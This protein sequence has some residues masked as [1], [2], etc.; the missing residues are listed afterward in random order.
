MKKIAYFF[1][2]LLI[3]GSAFGQT[4]TL[5]STSAA[6]TDN[7]LSVLS[8]PAWLGFRPHRGEFTLLFPYNDSTASQDFGMLVQL[9][10]LGFAGE[11]VNN[12]LYFYNRYT[13]GSGF[14]LGEG[15]YLG[16]S[17]D[18]Y[19]VVDWDGGWNIGMGYRPFSFLSAGAVIYDLNQPNRGGV[20]I[21][22]SY[23]FS[24]AFRPLGHKLTLSGDFLFTKP[25]G[26]SYGDSLDPVIRL[27]LMPLD[28]IKLTG[29]YRTDSK[30]FSLGLGLAIDN[31]AMGNF[32]N[33]D[34]DGK[35]L[36]SVTTVQ[37]SSDRQL[38]PFS[39][40]SHQIV[41]VTLD[42]KIGES[43]RMRIPFLSKH[44][45]KTLSELCEEIDHYAEDNKVDGLLIRFENPQLGFAQVQ[46]LRRALEK[47][48]A[49][50]KTLI[51]YSSEYTQR[52]YYL[53]TV[54]DE[55]YLMPVGMVDLKGLAAVMGY[56]KGTLNK[57]GIGV[58]VERVRDYKTAM[59]SFVYED[60]PAPEAEMMN[61]LLDDLYDQICNKMAEGRNWTLQE[62]QDKINNGP[63][64]S[65]T[66]LQNGLVDSLI[67]YDGIVHDIESKNYDLVSE[68]AYWRSPVY[69]EDWPDTRAPKIAVIYAEGA[70]THGDS[71]QNLF[72]GKIMGSQTIVEAIRKAREDASIDGII[73][74]VDSPGG[75][76]IASD[77]IY[78]EVQ[79]TTS[80]TKN[81]KPIYVSMGNVAGSGGYYIACGADTIIAEEGTITGSIGVI[82]GKFNLAGL[83]EKIGY[84]THPFK[85][86]EHSDAESMSRPWTE[87]ESALMR[88]SIEQVYQDFIS[89]VA[90]GRH[91]TK[92]QIDAVGQ[93]RVWTGTQGLQH[94]LV[95][96]IGGMDDA[97]NAMRTRLGVSEDAAV[98]LE[99]YPKPTG[100]F[101]ALSGK[102]INI[103]S[104]S[105]PPAIAEALE[106]VALASEFYTGAP[107][108]LMIYDIDIK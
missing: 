40:R 57:L 8:N 69:E 43:E 92:E 80:D 35:I 48:K 91:M 27:E 84:T 99:Y 29:E 44:D 36:N 33:M 97:L 64:Y 13:L 61:W 81:R 73:L 108:M 2:M 94:G 52:S 32:R 76:A 3:C 38:N 65:T 87:E 54:C 102:I 10:E 47:F 72:S 18:W 89:R 60:T 4:M 19:K 34:K 79:R 100:L 6:V 30:F 101:G 107:L 23:S 46:Q 37:F 28:G 98:E 59:N 58:Q 78:R 67:Y 83:H 55:I 88:A 105:L 104:S 20:S 106:P 82:A 25:T 51:A 103:K 75:D 1:V 85:R 56:W 90:Q 22:P 68:D 71:R 7:A 41:E 93:G 77:E 31:F 26:K 15:L 62:V 17:H 86:G 14:A 24:A 45:E 53:A 21:N 74:R 95:D 39:P 63:Y 16:V 9:G 66:A 50:G 49:Q 5:P 11:F 42:G 12:D 70:I 96:M